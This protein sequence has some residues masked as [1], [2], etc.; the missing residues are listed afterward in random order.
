VTELSLA[1]LMLWNCRSFQSVLE[2]ARLHRRKRNNKTAGAAGV[3]VYKV[4]RTQLPLTGF[5]GLWFSR[6][7]YSHIEFSADNRVRA[8]TKASQR[9]ELHLTGHLPNNVPKLKTANES[10]KL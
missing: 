5:F 10:R 4:V 2:P 1:E 7:S 9:R 8:S 6:A 3:T